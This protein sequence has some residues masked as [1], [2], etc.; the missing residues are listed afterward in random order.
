M[1]CGAGRLTGSSEFD[2]E[3]NGVELASRGVWEAT[4]PWWQVKC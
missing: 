3:L 4:V 2:I 1:A